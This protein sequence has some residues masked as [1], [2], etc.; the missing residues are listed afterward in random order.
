[1][2]EQA[3][4][5]AITREPLTGSKKIYVPGK[6]Y[7]IQVAMREITL[8]ETKLSNGVQEENPPVTVY[9]T[10]GAY[11][12]PAM[13]IDLKRGLPRIR[14]AWIRDR[15]DV[16]QLDEFTSAYCRSR[17]SDEKLDGLRF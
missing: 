12:D 10:S 13:S 16:E 8:S 5:N 1:M 9:D 11:T 3:S 14:E 6:M 2:E 15:N 17:L 7:N 4:K